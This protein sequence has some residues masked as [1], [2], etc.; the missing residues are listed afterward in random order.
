[1]DFVQRHN[2]KLS[3]S[4]VFT[5][6][7]MMSELV[8]TLRLKRDDLVVNDCGASLENKF[9]IFGEKENFHLRHNVSES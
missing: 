8:M 7:I 6:V 9:P 3:L 4:H 2:M 5:Y 1:M